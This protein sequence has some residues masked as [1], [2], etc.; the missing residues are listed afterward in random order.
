MRNRLAFLLIGA[1][2]MAP[3][4][5]LAQT[6][7]GVSTTPAADAP[8]QITAAPLQAG[9]DRLLSTADDRRG[10]HIRVPARGPAAFTDQRELAVLAGRNRVEIQDLPAT[11][12]PETLYWSGATLPELGRLKRGA[13]SDSA[14]GA[15]QA[16]DAAGP[17]RGDLFIEDGGSRRLTLHYHATGVTLDSDYRLQLAAGPDSA[18][19]ELERAMTLHNRTGTALT[20]ATVS[21]ANLQKTDSTP[22]RVNALAAGATLRIVEDAPAR[23]AVRHELMSRAAGHL[24]QSA[25]QNAAV[26]HRWL[27]TDLPPGAAGAPVTV[28]WAGPSGSAQVDR[29]QLE[30]T[31]GEAD[32]AI[33]AGRSHG[34]AVRRLQA[35]YR[36]EGGDGTEIAWRLRLTNTQSAPQMLLL[37][38]RLPGA[39]TLLEGEDDWQRTPVGL[40]RRIE[41][42]AGE[43]REVGYRVRV[44]SPGP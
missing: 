15:E 31:N 27:L 29:S 10:L 2:T 13:G 18:T 17:W 7:T 21:A 20:D 38:E 43:E 23:V 28:V 22:L 3:A 24:A 9:S 39:W 32:A 41:L 34:V 14:G 30:P 26:M 12:I 4:P 5:V 1:A 44:A 16:D 6:G 35:F 37:E 19:G 8:E 36:N 33:T 11:L 25:P 42:A 40:Q